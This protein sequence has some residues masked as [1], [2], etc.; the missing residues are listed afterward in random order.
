MIWK[1]GWFEEKKIVVVKKSM[2]LND[3]ALIV[4]DVCEEPDR[5]LAEA[6]VV[7]RQQRRHYGREVGVS[8]YINH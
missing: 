3:D 6:G 1:K 4:D 2:S 8:K 7:G 5:L